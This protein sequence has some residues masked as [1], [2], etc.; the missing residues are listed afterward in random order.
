MRNK[1]LLQYIYGFLNKKPPSYARHPIWLLIIKPFRKFL[2]VVIIPNI[3]INFLRIWLYRLVGYKIGSNVFIGMKCYLD[4]LNP[5]K[6]IIESNVT[7]SYGCYFS[8]HGKRQ[9]HQQIT[10]KEGVYIGM[11]SN[12]VATKAPIII[13]EKAIVGACSLVKQSIPDGKIVAGVPAKI[14]G[15]V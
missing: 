12:V 8:L 2:N 15:E 7:I 4:D 9:G 1:T 10:I 5:S 14:I 11:R 3:P 6:M 13:G